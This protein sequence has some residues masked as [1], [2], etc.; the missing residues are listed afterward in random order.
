[1]TTISAI[2]TA[3]LTLALLKNSDDDIVEYTS[4]LKLLK[5]LYYIQGYHLA[6]FDAP[7]F[8][9]KMEAWLHGPVVPSVYQW[10]KN[11][12]DEKLQNEAMDEKQMGALNLH[13]QQTK[14]ISEVLNIYNKYSAYGLR[15]KTHTEMPWLSVYEQGK[16]NE[17]TQDSL[18]NFFI[19]L[20]E[21]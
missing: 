12:T 18:K 20:V 8:K 11:L 14:L 9:D 4:R 21:K 19:P 7:L 10:V 3:K 6:M 2:D 16:N 13:P 17:I 5:L 15:D 1:M